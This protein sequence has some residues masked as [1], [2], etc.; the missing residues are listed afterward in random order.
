MAEQKRQPGRPR[1]WS[2]DAERMRAA[3]AAKREKRLAEEARQAERRSLEAERDRSSPT[4]ETSIE[5]RPGLNP[6]EAQPGPRT[7]H[8]ECQMVIRTLRDE[9]AW[10][11]ELYDDLA[12]RQWVLE[13]KYERALSR[14]RSHDS[15]GI[16]WLEEQLGAWEREV[17]EKRLKGLIEPYRQQARR[18][19]EEEFERQLE[20]AQR[21][22][23]E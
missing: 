19:Y 14:L 18:W 6:I 16:A 13:R 8:A 12:L 15:D 17:E 21:A 22:S 11:Y 9:L 7:E 2:S 23:T 3:R 10:R 4:N 20:L 1:K 5:S